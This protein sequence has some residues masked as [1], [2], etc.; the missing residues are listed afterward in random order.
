M[1]SP[2]NGA[3]ST[4]ASSGSGDYA[5]KDEVKSIG[6]TVMK[7]DKDICKLNKSINCGK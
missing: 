4:S 3:T 1:P 2:N 6:V 5:T 7:H